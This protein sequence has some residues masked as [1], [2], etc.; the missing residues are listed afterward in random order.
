MHPIVDLFHI[1]PTIA[2]LSKVDDEDSVDGG[3]F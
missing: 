2:L 1:Q 3:R